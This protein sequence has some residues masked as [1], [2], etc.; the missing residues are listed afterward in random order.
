MR[1]FSTS[2]A[3][4]TDLA[5]EILERYREKNTSTVPGLFSQKKVRN[6]FPVSLLRV[7][8]ENGARVTERPMGSYLTMEV[9]KIWSADKR[10]FQSAAETFAECIRAFLPDTLSPDAPCMLVALGN[11]G[12]TADAV[13]PMTAKHFIVTRHIKHAD[14]TLFDSLGL[15]ETVCV[16]P[17]VAGNTGMEAAEIA[18]GAAKKVT[19]GVVIVVD[20]LASCRLERLATTLQ[21][22]D[23]GLS[24][25]SGVY[26]ARPGLDQGSLGVPVLAIG[27]PTVVEVPT[28]ALDVFEKA[29]QELS[30]KGMLGDSEDSS[31]LLEQL[32]QTVGEQKGEGFF[33]TPKETDHIIKDIAKLIGYALNLALHREL[34]YEDIDEFLS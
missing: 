18:L 3:F 31:A 15:R 10:R 20:A 27:V 1:T 14:R 33:V 9:G 16:V 6:G 2:I 28:L 26:N 17:D 22:S 34:G 23:T 13:G 7:L 11:R 12:I 4:R 8:D 29:L 32:M 24:P 5:E 21:I 19:P 25:G 30:E